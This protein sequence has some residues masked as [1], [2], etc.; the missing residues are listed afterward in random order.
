MGLGLRDG[1]RPLPFSASG[2]PASLTGLALRAGL[3]LLLMLLLRLLLLLL[4][5]LPAGDLLRLRLHDI[6]R[7]Q[8]MT[9]LGGI[10]SAPAFAGEDA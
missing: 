7:L 5:L 9:C 4:L 2:A 6:W 1:L 3:L 8:S 10:C